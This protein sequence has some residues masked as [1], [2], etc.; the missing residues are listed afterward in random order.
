[1]R[2]ALHP[3]LDHPRP[4]AFA[5]RG[6]G[7]EREENTMEAFAH[8][9]DLGYSHVETDVRA[10]RDGVAVI[11]HDADLERM[12]G[13]PDRIAAL[14]W[15]DLAA[16][17]TRG[18]ARL[19]RIEELLADWPDLHVNI[20]PKDDAAV[21]PLAAA[22]AG[23]GAGALDRVC[24]GSFSPARTYALRARFGDALCWSPGRAGVARLYLA[25][26]GLP[27]GGFAFHAAQVP[28]YWGEI[29]LVTRRFV[30]TAHAR[31]VQVHVWTVDEPDEMA[32]LTDLGI[33]GIMTDRPSL[34]R[35]VLEEAG[36]WRR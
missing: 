12:C 19:A 26:W 10:T 25:G 11:F 2:H 36:K 9:V 13:R 17:R 16:I 21:A 1:M 31:A 34:L 29:P 23:A 7:L 20:E 24:I 15:A 6:G 30:A 18:G 22:I 4:I 8:A 33:D 3:F 14:D 5:H 27:A 28:P 35:R 32:R